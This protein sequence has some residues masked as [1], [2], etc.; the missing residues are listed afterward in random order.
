M[1]H[2]RRISI[3][4]FVLTLL[5]GAAWWSHGQTTIQVGYTLVRL[6][7][8]T[9][10]PVGTA[11]FSYTNPDGVLVTEAGVGAVDPVVRGRIF[12]DEAGTRTADPQRPVYRVDGSVNA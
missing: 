1:T 5:G 9:E 11:V 6:N 3:V 8:G 12:V 4:L 7:E 2:H 10:I